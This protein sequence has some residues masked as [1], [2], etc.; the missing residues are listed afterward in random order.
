MVQPIISSH[1]GQD[2]SPVI[3]AV[4]DSKSHRVQLNRKFGAISSNFLILLKQHL[5]KD[6]QFK[7]AQKHEFSAAIL[8]SIRTCVQEQTGESCQI[9]HNF[10]NV[11]VDL[12]LIP[13][14][15][16]KTAQTKKKSK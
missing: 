2:S 14:T 6:A 9:L 12:Q 8:E 16:A 1:L 10:I 7:A 4:E 11:K 5:A 15:T 13:E 3:Q